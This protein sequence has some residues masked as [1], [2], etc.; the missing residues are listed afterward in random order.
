MTARPIPSEHPLMQRNLRL[1]P[2]WWVL[3]WVWL[4][5]G[6]WVLYLTD[7]RGL[8]LGEALLFE[9][10]F[11]AVVIVSELPTG[12]IADRFGRRVSLVVGTT[13]VVI[14]FFAFGVGSSF[15][16]LLVAYAFFALAETSFSGA[17][18]AILYD[19][20]RA[21]GRDRDFTVW[22]GRL[23]ALIALAIGGFTVAGSL[24]VHWW[25]LWAPILLSA[26]LSAPAILLAWLMTEPPRTDERHTYLDTGRHAI[27][28]V[29]RNPAMLAAMVLMSVT[30]IAIASVSVFQQHFLRAAGIPVWG[31]GMF[32][33]GQMLVAAV[34]SWISSPLGNWLGFRRTMWIMPLGSTIALAAAA[35]GHLAL[36]PLFLFPALGWNVL[37][38]HFAEYLARRVTDSLRAS[39]MSIANIVGGLAAIAI[40]PLTGLGVD[41]LGFRTTVLI[42][43]AVLTSTAAV[44]FLAWA[45]SPDPGEIDG[46]GPS[47]PGHD[48]GGRLVI[49][50]PEAAPVPSG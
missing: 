45:R 26:A 32:V 16:V 34:G 48:P 41:R 14:A 17:D 6:I 15:L 1:L 33:A 19:S 31:V 38:P 25:P 7:E 24:M 44:A 40:V 21:V 23:N 49:D 13:A 11:S 3:R 39:V 46:S 18:T 12:M 20:L 30:T 50:A 2:W 35:P 22:H 10:V 27:T 36:Y 5:E 43:A 28:F 29:R 37:F 42:L 8:T 9:A 4:G 47:E